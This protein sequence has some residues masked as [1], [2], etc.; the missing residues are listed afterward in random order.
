[1]CICTMP[2]LIQLY[3]YDIQCFIYCIRLSTTDSQLVISHVISLRP[4]KALS[5]RFSTLNMRASR[6]LGLEGWLDSKVRQAFKKNRWI[7]CR[8][9]KVHLDATHLQAETSKKTRSHSSKCNKVLNKS[10]DTWCSMCRNHR[11]C[12]AALATAWICLYLP[13]YPSHKKSL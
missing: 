7:R 5:R 12:V 4:V 2:W 10:A 11:Q 9:D 8:F 13:V 3:L 1:M 6:F